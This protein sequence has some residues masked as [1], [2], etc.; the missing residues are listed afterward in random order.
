LLFVATG[1]WAQTTQIEG[2]VAS[3]DPVAKT[4]TF[5]DGR[6]VQFEPNARIFVNGREVTVNQV[7]PGAVIV[8]TTPAKPSASTRI[9]GTVAAI[10]PTAK[11]VTFTDGRV[12]QLDPS[13]RMFING[14]EVTF[15]DIKPGV[16]VA[17][18]PP[19]V[20]PGPPHPAAVP[21]TTLYRSQ[22]LVDASGTVA[23]VDRQNGIITLQD[24]RMLRVTSEARVWQAVGMSSVQTGSEVFL[25]NAMPMGYRSAGAV[26]TWTDRDVMGRVI[27]V[28]DTGNQIL[29]ADGTVVTVSPSTRMVMASGQTVTIRDLKPGDQV[30]VRVGQPAGTAQVV[31]PPATSPRVVA[32]QPAYSASLPAYRGAV[33]MA[34]QI[35]V[36]RQT[37]AP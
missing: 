4:I 21:S 8:M 12:V 27:R 23:S 6:V 19:V 5:T 14:Q 17:M 15:N 30:V 28:D 1:A 35:V 29:L 2:T 18:A 25:S 9:T 37:Q 16:A 32:D 26:Q 10:D 7:R 20:T 34:D 3:I 22:P 31:T 13:A 11:T 33:L 24:G 36:I